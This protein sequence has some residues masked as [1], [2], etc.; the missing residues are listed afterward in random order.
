MPTQSLL[1]KSSE[2][3]EYTNDN[4][5]SK[6]CYS[7]ATLAE[8]QDCLYCDHCFWSQDCVDSYWMLRCKVSYQSIYCT[9]CTNTHFSYSSQNCS[10]SCYLHFCDNVSNSLFCIGLVNKQNYIL[11]KKSSKKEVEKLRIDIREPKILEEYIQRYQQLC[12]DF[13]RKAVIQSIIEKC[14]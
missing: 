5:K 13:P 9:E 1:Q 4:E 14:S 7:C 10:S 12:D 6:D 2:N 3:C 11:N 8:S